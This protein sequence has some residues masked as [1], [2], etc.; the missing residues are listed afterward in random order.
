MS[1]ES[2]VLL[3]I[4]AAAGG[5]VNGLAGF[6]TALLSLGVWLQ[7]M[8]AWQAVAIVAAMSVV[9]GLQ[10]LWLIR[11]DLSSGLHKL[12]RF[13]LPALVGLPAG[14]AVLDLINAEMLKL[15]IAGFMLLYGAFFTLRKSLPQL[16]R[17]MPVIDSL[18]GLSGGFLGGAA[19]LSG[20]LPTMWCA[21]QPWSKTDTSAVLRPYNIVILGIAVL[22][23]AWSGYYTR[24]TL[25]MMAV[26]LPATLISSRLGVSVFRRLSNDQFRRLIIVL[27]FASGAILAINQLL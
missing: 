16:S 26:A 27:M 20:V 15:V 4:G 9:S 6:G 5:F 17:P 14:V 24:E 13:V 11:R 2:V 3:V 21:M 23:F 25:T 10:S 7:I 8:P 12:P 18:I 22:I 19:S 1:F